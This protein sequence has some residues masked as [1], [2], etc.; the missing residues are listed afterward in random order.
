V[1]LEFLPL[2]EASDGA[3]PP[4]ATLVVAARK[5]GGGASYL[6]DSPVAEAGNVFGVKVDA[7]GCSSDGEAWV[8]GKNLTVVQPPLGNTS[9]EGCKYANLQPCEEILVKG[10]SVRRGEAV[11]EP[12]ASAGA[13]EGPW[14]LELQY[15]EGDLKKRK[16]TFRWEFSLPGVRDVRLQASVLPFSTSVN[17]DDLDP[18]GLVASWDV[19]FDEDC[20]VCEFQVP[21]AALDT[22]PDKSKSFFDKAVDVIAAPFK[23]IGNGVKS[24][25]G[26]N[27]KKAPENFKASKPQIAKEKPGDYLVDGARNALL[28]P[29]T[30]YFRA[31][32][33][34]DDKAAGAPSNSVVLQEVPKPPPVEIKIPPSPSPVVP[35]YEVHIISYNGI[36]PPLNPAKD[37]YV[38]T[39]EAWLA[40]ITGAYTTDPSKKLTNQSVKPGDLI[41]KPDPDEP[42][43]F[44]VIVSWVESGVDWAAGAWQDIKAFAVNT[45]LEYT[46]LGALCDAVGQASTCQ[47]AAKIALDAALVAAGIPPDIP[48]FSQ[49]LD[50]GAE[51]MAAQAAAQVGIPPEVIEAATEE[52]GPYAGLALEVAEAELREELQQELEASLKKAAKDIQL[53]YASQVGWVPDGIP[54]RPDD[55]QPPGMTVRVTRKTGVPGGDQGCSLNVTDFVQIP[56]QVLNNPPPGWETSI[57]GLPTDLSPLTHYDFFINEHDIA[58]GQPLGF[59]KK[60]FVPPLA[61]G[62]SYEIPMTFKPN[63]YKSGFY[64][65]GVVALSDYILAWTIMHEFGNVTM[66]VGG[67]C[68]STSL[69][70][71]AKAITVSAEIVP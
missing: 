35:A 36:I 39:E 16:Q 54:V 20:G 47:T 44:E 18:A 51:Y 10:A 2:I 5:P 48:N 27:K 24:I 63:Y 69:T 45:V 38:V 33:I 25:F 46:G 8:P 29:S 42:S 66:S 34:V 49:A 37:C 11:Q 23:F 55:Y 31:V 59:D 22:S 60:L 68:G 41:C 9:L 14:V 58:S 15:F 64:P 13:P 6:F 21:L 1:Q 26:G 17:D 57:N 28:Q 62:E 56:A 52:G 30:Y 61:P 43:L 32:P 50:Q 19:H 67:S 71:P 53:G 65:L 40:S 3:E 70:L 12:P 7:G 4:P